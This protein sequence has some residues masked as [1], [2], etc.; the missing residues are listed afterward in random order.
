MNEALK[1]INSLIKEVNTLYDKVFDEFRDARDSTL[2]RAILG[3]QSNGIIA[4]RKII[5]ARKAR[6]MERLD[7]ELNAMCEVPE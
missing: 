1:E 3:G 4:V 6:L 5:I 7:R 2:E